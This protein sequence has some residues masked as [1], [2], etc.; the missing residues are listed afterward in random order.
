MMLPLKCAAVSQV[1]P[2][3]RLVAVEVVM[4]PEAVVEEHQAIHP[5]QGL[6]T[7]RLHRAVHLSQGSRNPVRPH[8][9]ETTMEV[10][11][12]YTFHPHR[13][14]HT[15]Q[16]HPITLVQASLHPLTLLATTTIIGL[17][18]VT[19]EFQ[20]EDRSMTLLDDQ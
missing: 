17:S 20:L 9:E 14:H 8:L 11:V 18:L 6:S 12:L 10:V 19:T 13:A 2:V 16:M 3:V 5:N 4:A 7:C 1:H 15:Q